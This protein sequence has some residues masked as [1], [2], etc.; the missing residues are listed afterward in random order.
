M[1]QLVATSES[2]THHARILTPDE[3]L[4]RCRDSL[5]L[6]DHLVITRQRRAGRLQ[7]IIYDRHGDTVAKCS[8]LESLERWTADAESKRPQADP[9]LKGKAA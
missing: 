7:H 8:S 6:V 4:G 3:R 1:L 5:W 9:Q 2:M